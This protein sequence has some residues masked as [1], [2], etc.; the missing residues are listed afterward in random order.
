[1]I[2][3]KTSGSTSGKPK[4]LPFSN[5]AIFATMMY[6][7]NS[8]GTKT[9]DENGV[10]AVCNAPIQHGYGWMTLFLNLMGGNQILML[11]G[12]ADDVATYYTYKPSYIYGTPLTLKQ[13]M[14]STPDDTD[15]SFLDAFFCAGA[16]IPEEEYEIGMAYLKAHHST[17]EIRNNY[18]IS[19]TLCVG[20]APDG[21]PHKKG[22]VGKLDLGPDWLIVDENDNEVKYNE[23][24]ELIV[25][26][27]TLCQGYFR[28]E[29]AT[30]EAFF[31]RDGKR[32]FRTGDFFSLDEEG[33][34]S[35]IG[36][37]RRFFFAEGVTDKVNCETIEQALMDLPSV[38]QAAIVI[39][40]YNSTTEGARA[41]VS[42]VD[43]SETEES[44]RE[45]L[46]ET[47]QSYQMP[48]EIVILDEIP[49][50]ESGKI[51]YKQ[52]ENM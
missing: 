46:Q 5:S 18:G 38:L 7:S 35:F 50:M 21:I 40:K 39:K 32:F 3:L 44:I 27:I 51:N 43:K 33:Y 13:F 26:S 20:T 6:I 4:T 47:L 48:R 22:T 31:E 49:L 28:D 45:K 16:S 19:E 11:G 2:F 15:L 37:K 42:L 23:T 10:R 24:G 17:G 14:E 1:M 52:L 41:F 9:R 12:T 25:S 8:T 30:E 34:V 29:K 36:R